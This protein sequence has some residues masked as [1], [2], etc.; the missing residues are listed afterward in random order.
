MA[1]NAQMVEDEKI[2]AR[3]QQAELGQSTGASIPTV[4]GV[5]VQ[6]A[7]RPVV[8]GIPARSSLPPLTVAYVPD[9]PLAEIVVM[10]YRNAVLCFAMIDVFTTLLNLLSLFSE[11]EG[12]W[13]TGAIG[14]FFILGPVAGLIGA[15]RLNRPCV[16]V[17]LAF[18]VLKLIYQLFMTWTFFFFWFLF[19]AIIQV[20]ITKIVATFWSAL[21]AIPAARRPQLL[22]SDAKDAVRMVYW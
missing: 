19:L 2:A 3:L 1:N 4:Q 17:Y 20:W 18:C 5:P 13:L 7:N 9:L 22:D 21:G 14:L 12:S 10:N 15:N 16:T 11:K 6:G 8:V